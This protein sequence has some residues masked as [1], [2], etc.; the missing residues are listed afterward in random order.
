MNVGNL[1]STKGE[2]TD[3]VQVCFPPVP[4]HDDRVPTFVFLI[5]NMERLVNVTDKV[6]Q[7]HQALCQVI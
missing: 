2:R 5:T 3:V 1:V 4:V 6:R 7:E